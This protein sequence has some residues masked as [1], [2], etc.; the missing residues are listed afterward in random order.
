MFCFAERAS[1]DFGWCGRDGRRGVDGI[2]G[3]DGCRLIGAD[4]E[5]GCAG[6]CRDGDGERG[7]MGWREERE[8]RSEGVTTEPRLIAFPFQSEELKCQHF[9]GKSEIYNATSC[10]RRFWGKAKYNATSCV[11]RRSTVQFRVSSVSA[12]SSGGGRHVALARRAPRDAR[13]RQPPVSVHAPA[14]AYARAPTARSSVSFADEKRTAPRW[15]CLRRP[16]HFPAVV[17]LPAP[18]FLK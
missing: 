18:P 9:L 1:I 3:A 11:R 7:K 17:F 15:G 6:R 2:E 4:R 16:K 5:A 8:W 10:V 14:R 12:W 13:P